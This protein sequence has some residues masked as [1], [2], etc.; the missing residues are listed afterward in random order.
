[1]KYAIFSALTIAV[2]WG[3]LAIAQIWVAPF[4]SDVFSKITI[5]AVILVGIIVLIILVV[6]EYLSDK[7]FRKDGFID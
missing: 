5:S 7:K 6:R 3:L 1:M 4:S 2:L